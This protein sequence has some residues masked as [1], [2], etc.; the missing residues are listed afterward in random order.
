M[1][2]ASLSDSEH[3]LDSLAYIESIT[4]ATNDIE[5][6]EE[7]VSKVQTITSKC[8]SQLLH[9]YVILGCNTSHNRT[10]DIYKSYPKSEWDLLFSLCLQGYGQSNVFVFFCLGSSYG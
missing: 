7:N 4:D 1:F 9:P 6:T 8:W 2:T 10:E 5:Q 3:I